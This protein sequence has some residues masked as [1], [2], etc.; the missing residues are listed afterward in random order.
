MARYRTTVRTSSSPEAAFELIADFR[1]VADWDPGVSRSTLPDGVEPGVG[2]TY[3]VKAGFVDLEYETLEFDPPR[4]TVLEAVSSTLRSYDVITFEPLDDGGTDVTYDAT[5]EL[6][7]LF[8]PLGL[9][10]GLVFDR[11]G[12]KAAA[13]LAKA[14]DGDIVSE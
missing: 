7:G 14:L 6:R 10:L 1:T 3:S 8:S 2:A 13:G 9:G 12:D 5:L 11:I 4:R